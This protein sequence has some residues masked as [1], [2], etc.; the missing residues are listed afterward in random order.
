MEPVAVDLR[1][2]NCIVAGPRRSGRTSALATAVDSLLAQP[3]V[4]E[5][6]VLTP[7][8]STLGETPNVASTSR[9]PANCERAAALFA[10]ELSARSADAGPLV[11]IVDDAED[12]VE[13]AVAASLLALVRQ[14]RDK[15]VRVLAAVERNAAHRAF[16]NW[17]RELRNDGHGLLL[18]PEVEVDGELVGV[19]LPKGFR[20]EYPPGRGY[21]VDRG[22]MEL[23][24][25]AKS[26]STASNAPS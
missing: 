16:G 14:G 15:G 6:H 7:R 23:I 26:G 5:V 2:A 9:G 22:R 12:L 3:E 13:G 18:Q 10:A 21:L 20:R 17:I 25:V 11:V 24:Q 1:H 19:R 8:T 4:P